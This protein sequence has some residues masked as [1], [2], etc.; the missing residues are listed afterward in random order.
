MVIEHVIFIKT[1]LVNA[2]GHHGS[3]ADFDGVESGARLGKGFLDADAEGGAV[4]LF[5]DGEHIAAKADTGAFYVMCEQIFFHPV[6]D[7][8]FGD[9][10]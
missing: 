8:S 4:R 5:T 6:R 9:K 2:G 10:A 3:V 1:S 7:I